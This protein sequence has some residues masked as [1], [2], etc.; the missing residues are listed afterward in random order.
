MAIYFP[1]FD[2]DQLFKP[3]VLER[4]VWEGKEGKASKASLDYIFNSQGQ[5]V[6]IF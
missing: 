1:E 2:N 3:L 5:D 4:Q 6:P